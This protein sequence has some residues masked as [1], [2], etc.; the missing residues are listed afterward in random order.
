MSFKQTESGAWG[1]LNLLAGVIFCLSAT[2][3]ASDEKVVNWYGVDWAPA[4]ILQGPQKGQGYSDRT[5]KM[6]VEA[7][8]GYQHKEIWTSFPRALRALEREENA[9]FAASFYEWLDSKTGK[10]REDIVW[11]APTLLFYWH[12]LTVLKENRAKFEMD[13]QVWLANHI[14]DDD[15]TLGL[16]KGRVY[17]P[18]L[19]PIIAQHQSKAKILWH[20]SDKETVEG[21][22]RLLLRGRVDYMV[23]YSYMQRY[24]EKVLNMPDRF[25]FIP[26]QEHAGKIG[27][28]AIACNNSALGRELVK[29]INQALKTLRHTSEFRNANTDWFM[30]E[31]R[32]EEYWRLWEEE[33]LSR[34]D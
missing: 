30:L 24:A 27:L 20:N 29:K 21:Q 11:S 12:G 1:P 9:C 3:V 19:D 28:G 8:P 17:G 7:L 32:E 26:I 4:W 34:S 25:E 2:V 13:G 18:S 5:Q 10:M 6:L 16:Q 15:K 33:Y 22:Y 14:V 31:G 23:E